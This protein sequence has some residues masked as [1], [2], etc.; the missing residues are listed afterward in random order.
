MRRTSAAFAAENPDL[1]VWKGGPLFDYYPESALG[2][3]QAVVDAGTY[4]LAIALHPVSLDELMAVADAGLEDPDVVMP[5]K[6]TFFSPKILTGLFL[7][8]HA[9]S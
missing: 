3:M 5:E 2:E 6:S 7:Y 8:R 9:K 4:E 1:L